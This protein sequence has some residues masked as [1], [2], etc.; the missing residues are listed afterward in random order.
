M[1]YLRP[2]SAL[3]CILLTIAVTACDKEEYGVP[4]YFE[5]VAVE[6][7]DDS[8]SGK[9]CSTVTFNVT[10]GWLYVQVENVE[11]PWDVS[12]IY[13]VGMWVPETAENVLDVSFYTSEK[14]WNPDQC[15]F[16]TVRGRYDI[17]R[18][19]K[20]KGFKSIVWIIYHP[21][22]EAPY[23][24]K[25]LRFRKELNISEGETLIWEIEKLSIE[26]AVEQSAE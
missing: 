17:S 22:G 7:V 13:I 14:D 25:E 24:V 2:F 19:I 20:N 4:E 15:S 10:G 5:T 16:K 9:N 12:P 18:G 8:A 26:N 6:S 11:M 23:D 1:K 21:Y 3:V